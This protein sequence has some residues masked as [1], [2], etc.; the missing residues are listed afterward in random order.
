MPKKGRR[1]GS[2]GGMETGR[3]ANTTPTNSNRKRKMN[4]NPLSAIFKSSTAAAGGSVSKGSTP[5]LVRKKSLRTTPLVNNNN[6]ILSSATTR[7]PPPPPPHIQNMSLLDLDLDALSPSHLSTPINRRVTRQMSSSSERK[8][9]AGISSS[10]S[11]KRTKGEKKRT[12]AAAAEALSHQQEIHG[13]HKKRKGRSHQ[14]RRSNSS[15]VVSAE[16][17]TI[18]L[19]PA[20]ASL[21]S[22]S[23]SIAAADF[24][25][26]KSKDDDEF[27]PLTPRLLIKRYQSQGFFEPPITIDETVEEIVDQQPEKKKETTTTTSP[28]RRGETTPRNASSGK[29]RKTR[30]AAKRRKNITLEEGE[31][32]D[33]TLDEEIEIIGDVIK[34]PEIMIV[35]ESIAPSGRRSSPK[36]TPKWKKLYKNAKS[37]I[38]S[39]RTVKFGRGDRDRDDEDHRSKRRRGECRRDSKKKNSYDPNPVAVVPPMFNPHAAPDTNFTSGLGIVPGGVFQFH[40]GRE[41]NVPT[42]GTRQLSSTRTMQGMSNV[43]VPTPE[44][45]IR[46]SG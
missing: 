37:K 12:A 3:G 35:H 13:S 23:K 17:T 46:Q 41:R 38:S 29:K 6:Q 31:I 39:R 11:R 25:P 15:D 5:Q 43:F 44:K 10:S 9:A 36:K 19:T 45:S 22:S 18:P 24:I 21:A 27:V 40:G 4:R 28:K 32:L 1:S 20:V 8:N 2:L 16:D 42:M 26:L 30:S 7:P 34:S 33:D 14:K